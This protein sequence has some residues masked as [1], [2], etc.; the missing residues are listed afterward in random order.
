[1]LTGTSA[2]DASLLVVAA[3][4]RVPAPQTAAHLAILTETGFKSSSI[5]MLQNKAELVLC[6]GGES[7]LD[8]HADSCR[9]FSLGSAADGSALIPISAELGH[10]LDAVAEWLANLPEPNR[11]AA[12]AP[13]RFTIVRSFD[14]NKPGSCALSTLHGGVLGGSL[15][16]G[17]LRPGD[18]VELRPGRVHQRREPLSSSPD[19]KATKSK[20]SKAAKD[21]E[22]IEFE[23][24]I[25]RVEKVMSGKAELSDGASPGGLVAVQVDLDPSLTRADACCGMV[26][27][28]PGSL[29]P[30]MTTVVLN[31]TFLTPK[32]LGLGGDDDDDDDDDES[33]DSES[34]S[35]TSTRKK[36]EKKKKK[37]KETKK[38]WKPPKLSAGDRVRLSAGSSCTSARIVRVSNS[39]GRAELKL[40]QVVCAAKGDRVAVEILRDSQKKA[41]LKTTAKEVVASSRGHG[42]GGEKAF[43]KTSTGGE[44]ATRTGGA[45]GWSLVAF[46]EIEDGIELAMVGGVV[47]EATLSEADHKAGTAVEPKTDDGSIEEDKPKQLAYSDWRKRFADLLQQKDGEMLNRS[48]IKC[49]PPTFTRDGGARVVWENFGSTCKALSRPPSHLA[50]FLRQEGGL[51]DVNLAGRGALAAAVSGTVGVDVQLRIQTRARNVPDKVG[52]LLRHYCSEFVIC[53]QCRGARTTLTRDDDEHVRRRG[54]THNMILTCSSCHARGFVRP[55]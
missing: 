43:R 14:T 16:R 17:H 3:N 18:L 53:K 20:K 11:G 24:I 47:D 27:G 32:Q 54:H 7:E 37:E 23:P 34:D 9:R 41:P 52:R 26:A 31:L 8:D 51:G 1:M 33:E 55:L 15:M 4:E 12:R 28:K 40:D 21:V 46:G 6:A 38:S 39:R 50:A 25:T 2:F 48:N 29:P 30:V 5:C 22:I 44:A 10:N 35:E 13:A 19:E 49:P 45:S 42:G 36:E